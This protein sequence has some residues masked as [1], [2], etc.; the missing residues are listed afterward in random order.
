LLFLAGS[1]NGGFCTEYV[2]GTVV[3]AESQDPLI[4]VSVLIEGTT[5][6]TVSDFNGDFELSVPSK[7]ETYF[8]ILLCRI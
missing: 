5:T 6:G 1:C 8:G 2:K 4:G 7:G 3:D